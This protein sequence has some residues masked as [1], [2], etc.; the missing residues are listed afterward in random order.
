[1]FFLKPNKRISKTKFKQY[2]HGP[3]RTPSHVKEHFEWLHE[4]RGRKPTWYCKHCSWTNAMRGLVR[5]LEH[6]MFWDSIKVKSFL[7][8]HGLQ[9]EAEV[10]A[11]YLEFIRKYL[12]VGNKTVA[13]SFRFPKEKLLEF[14]AQ[15]ELQ[16]IQWCQFMQWLPLSYRAGPVVPEAQP[17]PFEQG[18]AQRRHAIALVASAVSVSAGVNTS[19]QHFLSFVAPQYEVPGRIF[20][21]HLQDRARVTCIF[22]LI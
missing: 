13:C 17:E 15:G 7:R 2:K 21:L 19:W 18:E 3:V 11:P 14:A 8:H 6:L 1:M 16:A 10:T 5:P 4:D 20:Y 12:K 22:P 9:S